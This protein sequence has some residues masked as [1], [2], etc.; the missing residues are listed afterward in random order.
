M[1]RIRS[2]ESGYG[3]LKVLKNLSLHIS[4]GEIVTI[5]GANG[6]GKSTLL[7]T[8]VGLIPLTAGDMEFDGISINNLGTEKTAAAGCV[9]VPEGR[10]LFGPMT[11][12][13]NLRLGAYLYWKKEQKKESEK[14]IDEIYEM[15]PVV[16]E[17]RSQLAGT[18]SGGE[19][20]MLAIGRALMTRPK[21]LMMDEPSMGIAP[22]I[23]KE[24]FKTI[25]GLSEKG[26]TILLVEQNARVALKIAGRGY[27][28][29][30][31]QIVLEGTSDD[32]LNNN[33]VQRAYLGKEYKSIDD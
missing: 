22:I 15:F 30:T 27:V 8:I 21:L 9:L 20:Q 17:R 18:L 33:D 5:I 16:K 19:Q 28:L 12:E 29:E 7:K 14:I 4:P 2:L 10:Q 26:V 6:A 1:L 25:S 3:Q 23:V 13:E 11:V 32:L 24:I 31:G